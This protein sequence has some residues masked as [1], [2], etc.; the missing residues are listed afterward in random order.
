MRET[1]KSLKVYFLVAGTI[2]AVL[3]LRDLQ[4]AMRFGTLGGALPPSWL[5]AIWFSVISHLVLGCAYLWSG[6][7]L[8]AELQRGAPWIKN[9]LLGSI[10]AL[11]IDAALTGSILGLDVGRSAM[12]TPII[13]LVISVYLLANVRRLSEE[14]MA[15]QP[16]PARVA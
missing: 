1:E 2:G 4:A 7:R 12:T 3:A 10:V 13:G 15:K 11:V 14:A 6:V 16:P 5:L 8:T 9:V